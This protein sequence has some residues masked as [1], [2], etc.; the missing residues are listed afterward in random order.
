MPKLS[1]LAQRITQDICAQFLPQGI[2]CEFAS[3]V[4]ADR[5]ANRRDMEAGV[6]L[7]VLSANEARADFYGKQPIEGEEYE[8]PK[9]VAGAKIDISQEGFRI[10]EKA[11]GDR[12]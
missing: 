12:S 8:R 11:D 10:G 2:T 6:R 3:P 1:L 7:G 4:P 9:P 5:E